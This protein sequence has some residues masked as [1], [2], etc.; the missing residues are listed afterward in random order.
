MCSSIE[1]EFLKKSEH[2]FGSSKEIEFLK[3]SEHRFGSS[4]EIEFKKRLSIDLVLA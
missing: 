2:R 4:L 1:I 3:K